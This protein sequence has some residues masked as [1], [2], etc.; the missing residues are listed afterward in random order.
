M[1][2]EDRL[3]VIDVETAQAYDH[4]I[5]VAAV[6]VIGKAISHRTFVRRV[7]PRSAMAVRVLPD[8]ML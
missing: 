7:K 5:E 4:L 6:E 2:P 3:V 1:K 8:F